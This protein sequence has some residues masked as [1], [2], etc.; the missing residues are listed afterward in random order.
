MRFVS[1]EDNMQSGMIAKVVEN[2]PYEFVSLETLGELVDGEIDMSEESLALWRGAHENYTFEEK[3]GVTTV[4][5]DLKD[6]TMP[7]EMMSMFKDMW[8][9]ALA[10]LKQI[11][12]AQ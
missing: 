7:E 5:V 6:G 2:R 12:E 4:T 3:D 9:Q 1:P 11:V 10:T 8:P